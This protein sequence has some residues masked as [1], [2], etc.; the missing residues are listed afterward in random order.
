MSH[1][2]APLTPAG[3]LRLVQRCQSRPVAHVAAEAGVSRQC[4]GKWKKRFEQFGEAGLLDRSSAPRHSPS[5]LAP[6]VVSRI[7]WLRRER[8][9]SARRIVIELAT[10]GHTVSASTVGR[11][12]V[13][14]G[15]N[16]R[17]ALDPDGSLNRRP[18]RPIRARYPGH[19]VHLDVKKVGRIPDGGGWRVHGRGSDQHRATNRVADRARRQRKQNKHSKADD[20]SPSTKLG[21]TYLHSMIDGFSRLAYTEALPDERGVTAAGFWHRA[22][23][24]FAAHGISRITRVITDNGPCY[25]SAVFARAIRE[26]GRHQRIKPFTPR[27]NGKV[28]RYQRIVAEEL[29]YARVWKSETQRR[30]ALLV[31]NIHYNYHRPHTAAGNQPPATRLPANVTNVMTGNS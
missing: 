4:L 15:L 5:E 26:A 12:L 20:T 10:E 17:R 16:N 30:Q 31:W 24:F 13:R 27:H 29:L 3:R 9:W 25:R 18:P 1:R 28:E 22:R 2:N 19:M 21:Y 11:W 7:E 8:K 6:Q 14:L 23:A